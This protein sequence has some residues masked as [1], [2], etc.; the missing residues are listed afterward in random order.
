[1]KRIPYPG[2]RLLG[3]K[4]SILDSNNYDNI[5]GLRRYMRLS[6]PLHVPKKEKERERERERE[7]A[8]PSVKRASEK[9]ASALVTRSVARSRQDKEKGFE[10]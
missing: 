5:H 1:M 4:R 8:S 10:E 7:E 3:S 2:L 9:I 6:A